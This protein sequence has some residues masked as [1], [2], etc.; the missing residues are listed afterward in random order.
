M[1]VETVTFVLDLYDGAQDLVTRGMAILQPSVPVSDTTNH[2]AV[3]SPVIAYFSDS[4]STVPLQFALRACD[5]PDLTP[6]GWQW[7]IAFVNVPGQPDGFSFFLNAA[8][9]ATQYYSAMVPVQAVTPMASYLPLPLSG[10]YPGGTAEFLRADQTWD[11]PPGGSGG[12]TGAAAIPGAAGDG[13]TDDTTAIQ[14]ALNAAPAGSVTGVPFT[15]AGYLCGALIIPAGAKLVFDAGAKLIA[16]ASLATSWL[17]A[18]TGVVHQGTAIIGGTFDASAAT[19]ANVTAVLFFDHETDCPNLRIQNNRIINAPVHGIQLGA[20]TPTGTGSLA[21]KW[22][23]GNSVEEHGLAGTGFGIYADYI[24]NVLIDGNYVYTAG[25]DDSI[26][27]GHSGPRWLGIDAHLRCTNN[28][29]VNGQLQYP[30]SDNAEIVNNT[31]VNNTIQ[32]DGNTANYVQI[33]GNR[34]F[35]APA[36]STWAGISH[37]GSYGQIIGN[38]I[39]VS[40]GN[41][42]GGAWT[43]EIVANNYITSTAS[44]NAGYGIY[45]GGG[46]GANTITGNI[47]SGNFLYGLYAPFSE[48]VVIGNTFATFNGLQVAYCEYN[49]IMAN[50]FNVANIGMVGTPGI[51]TIIFGNMGS[52]AIW[53]TLLFPAATASGAS[54]NIPPGAVPTSPNSGDVWNSSG[55]LYYWNGTSAQEILQGLLP[56]NNLSDLGSVSAAVANLGLG[57][58]ATQNTSAFDAAGTA[59][60]E[61]ARA[62]AAEALLAPK[63]SPALTGAPTAPTPA[64]ADSSTK[65]ATTAFVA[66]AIP[67][68]LPPSGTA[69]GDLGSTY[70]AP[71]VVATH[72]ASPL[73]VTQGGTGATTAGAAQTAL[74]LGSAAT[75]P[76]SAFDA[77]GAASTAQATAE[78]FA[79]SAVATETTRAEAAE[80]LLA[81]KS[82][83][84]LTGVPTA[85]TAATS[86]ATTQVATD[87]FVHAAITAQGLGSAALQP[88]SAFDAAGLAATAQSA[89]QTFATAAVGTET[90]RAEAAEGLLAPK[91]SPALTGTPTAPTAAALTSGTQI[92][93]TAYADAAVAAETARAESIETQNIYSQRIFAV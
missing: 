70:P 24:G 23:T 12:S 1:A 64:G 28:Y 29:C 21:M 7:T 50:N 16:P 84:A 54:L 90:A 82:S 15:P 71:T 59:A 87:A 20:S 83:P 41:G 57:T 37:W 14:A 88:T 65:L 52:S 78:T 80:T 33:T 66:G 39:Q 48:S 13:V 8:A 27:L 11:V 10:T 25:S 46:G 63:A 2:Q 68:S 92:A 31:V 74:G 60:A 36:V 5:D 32:N 19:S 67:A 6:S 53:G 86:D 69:S 43:N 62:E 75:Q 42:I 40:S 3:V 51:G 81:P 91:A 58:A 93:T 22:V 47:V 26:E 4:N 73:P 85:P 38:Y 45:P 89:A 17:S 49:V 34:V 72:L 56:S 79:T 9:G 18:Q 61:T 30:F 55:S 44:P 76:S 77:S 35:N